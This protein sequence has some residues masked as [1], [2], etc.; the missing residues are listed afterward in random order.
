MWALRE[1]P[2][3]PT[4]LSLVFQL[5]SPGATEAGTNSPGIIR[6]PGITCPS[7]PELQ[8][9]EAPPTGWISQLQGTQVVGAGLLGPI[10]DLKWTA[11][12]PS[13]GLLDIP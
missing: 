4:G 5:T 13:P 11:S 2:D 9:T 8:G 7:S 12:Y 3:P 10:P 6:D 1:A